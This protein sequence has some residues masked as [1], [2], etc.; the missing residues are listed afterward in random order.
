MYYYWPGRVKRTC[1]NCAHL[2]KRRHALRCM[3]RKDGFGRPGEKV[4]EPDADA[5]G[6][7]FWKQREDA[8]TE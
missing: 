8:P 7:P 2:E 1:R 4:E 5:A 6:C 3:A